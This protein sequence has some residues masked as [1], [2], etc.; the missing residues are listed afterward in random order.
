[1]V[2]R[3]DAPNCAKSHVRPSWPPKSAWQGEHVTYDASCDVLTTEPGI[4]AV[5]ST[6]LKRGAAAPRPGTL[7]FDESRAAVLN[8]FLPSRSAAGSGSAAMPPVMLE[9]GWPRISGTQ[10]A[11]TTH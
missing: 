4:F 8:R 9:T 5:S 3:S 1:M 6:L 7:T 11:P 2:L 10:S